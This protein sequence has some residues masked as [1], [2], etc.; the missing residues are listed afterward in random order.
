VSRSH[1]STTSQLRV[2]SPEPESEVLRHRV[3]QSVSRLTGIAET[4]KV[5]GRNWGNYV[6]DDEGGLRSVLELLA[7]DVRREAKIAGAVEGFLNGLHMK[8]VA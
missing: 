5:I 3:E 1:G 2:E 7:A 6:D 8:A 4:L